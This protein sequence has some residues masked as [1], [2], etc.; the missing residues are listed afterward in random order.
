MPCRAGRTQGRLEG[1]SLGVYK[2]FDIGHEIGY[3]A[4]CLQIWKQL[5]DRQG[6]LL[7]ARA[8]KALAL[9]EEA[10][11]KVPLH[12]PQ[13]ESLQDAMDTVKGKFKAAA[14]L[15][16]SPELGAGEDQSSF[17][18]DK[19]TLGVSSSPSNKRETSGGLK[20]LDF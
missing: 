2:G 16:G 8:I 11:S 14:A 12:D 5:S 1:K 3:Y 20:G 13:D 9:L 7:S 17:E 19:N 10:V 4:G 18:G 6:N 15:F